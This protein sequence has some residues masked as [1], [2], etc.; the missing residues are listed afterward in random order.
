MKSSTLNAPEVFHLKVTKGSKGPLIVDQGSWQFRVGRTSDEDPTMVF[1]PVVHRIQRG[2][3]QGHVVGQAPPAGVQRTASRTPFDEA[4]MPVHLT[5]LE[6]IFDFILTQY[7]G[8]PAE[9]ILVTEPLVC[10]PYWRNEVA[11]LLFEAY[12]APRVGF[13][14]DVQAAAHGIDSG[15][16]ISIGNASTCIVAVQGGRVTEQVRIDFGGAK[17]ADSMLRWLQL[18]YPSFPQKLTL[19]QAQELVHQTCR[20]ALDYPKELLSYVENTVSI[21]FP[22]Q[23]VDQEEKVK[24]EAAMADRRREQVTRMR[25]RM[26]AIKLEKLEAK[27][28]LVDSL[29]KLLHSLSKAEDL[30]LKPYGYRSQEEVEEALTVARDDLQAYENKLAGVVEEVKKAEPDYSL[31]DI[32]D[33]Q[34][35]PEQL[36][37]KRRQRLLK[38]SADARERQRQEKEA[39]EQ[40]EEARRQAMKEKRLANFEQWCSDLYAERQTILSKLK[41]K[42]RAKEALADRRSGASGKRLKSVMSLANDDNEQEADEDVGGNKRKKRTKTKRAA[43]EVDDGFGEDDAD[44]LIYRQI[45]RGEIFEDDDGD[46]EEE[47]RRRLEE[48][49]AELEAHDSRRFFEVLEAE[50]LQTLSIMHKIAHPLAQSDAMAEA[51]QLHVNV[52]RFRVPE[53]LFQPH[54]V[55]IDQAG[56]VEVCEMVLRRA[57]IPA[58]IYLTGGLSQLPGLK[59]RLECELRSI[60]PVDAPLSIQF[61]DPHLAA[62]RGAV[63]LAQ[64]DQVSWLTRESL[65]K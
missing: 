21:Q 65:L 20:V 48:I 25:E 61:L 29:Q 36:A 44:W 54:I 47:Q 28:H 43:E 50:N 14:S 56:L 12:D 55:G 32:A 37:T 38:A 9:G 53:I 35:D 41:A 11:E 49:E 42:Q 19:P 2:E 52:E 57:G 5:T 46:G 64:S 31:L 4:G 15:L 39:A 23:Q 16:V 59:E 22:F 45:S 62:W 34:L 3:E 1:A 17:A 8:V 40:R 63:R 6:H 30:N 24:R 60:L 13:I 26:E 18:K 10:P 58:N 33:D 27:K 7:G 51:H